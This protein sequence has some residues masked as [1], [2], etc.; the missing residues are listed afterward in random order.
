M[1]RKR[2]SERGSTAPECALLLAVV[3]LASI[4]SIS[5]MGQGAKEVFSSVSFSSGTAETQITSP[6]VDSVQSAGGAQSAESASDHG[7]GI[8]NGTG[9][10]DSRNELDNHNNLG[11][12]NRGQSGPG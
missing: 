7:G 6:Q 4:S 5:A 3:A 11:A 9:D 10:I 1:R 2:F 8:R 12:G